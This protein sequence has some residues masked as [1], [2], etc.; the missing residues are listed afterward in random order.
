MTTIPDEQYNATCP[1]CGEESLVGTV[2]ATNS[3][4]PL[5]AADYDFD[6][7]TPESTEIIEVKCTSCGRD[8]IDRNHY[9]AHGP[10]GDP[11]DCVEDTAT[12]GD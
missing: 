5:L 10:D 9:F 11:C 8:D 6:G 2:Q 1:Y 12:P 3:N 7:G 4:V